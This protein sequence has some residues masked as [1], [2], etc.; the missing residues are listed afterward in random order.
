MLTHVEITAV[1]APGDCGAQ[2]RLAGWLAFDAA[3]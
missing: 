2:S 3:K 1:A